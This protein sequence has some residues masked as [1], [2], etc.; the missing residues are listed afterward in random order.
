MAISRLQ[1]LRR[2]P[3]LQPQTQSWQYSDMAMPGHRHD[4]MNICHGS[5]NRM[6]WYWCQ[7]CNLIPLSLVGHL[8][9]LI[10]VPFAPLLGV[11][12][13]RKAEP[14]HGLL[15]K[16]CNML[17]LAVPASSQHVLP[18]RFMMISATPSGCLQRKEGRKE[19]LLIPGSQQG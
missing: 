7:A 1:M 16:S 11:A 4:M 19:D 14:L 17:T 6:S 10:L 15:W 2:H 9:G 18:F 5:Q 13:H 8:A 12:A 3:F